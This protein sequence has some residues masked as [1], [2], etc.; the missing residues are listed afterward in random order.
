MRPIATAG[1]AWSVCVPLCVSVAK[2]EPCKNGWCRLGQTH[3]GSRNYV[4][5][6]SGVRIGATWR[7]GRM[8]RRRCGYRYR[9]CSNLFTS[10]IC[11]AHADM[12]ALPKPTFSENLIYENRREVK[13]VVSHPIQQDFNSASDHFQPITLTLKR[14]TLPFIQWTSFVTS[15]LQFAYCDNMKNKAQWKTLST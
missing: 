1:V 9:Y 3:V 15:I 14:G 2:R 8:R 6:R 5:D 11:A 13:H 10:G 12:D 4:W 7:I